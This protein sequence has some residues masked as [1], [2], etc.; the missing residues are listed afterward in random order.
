MFLKQGLVIPYYLL[1]KT[2]SLKLS[3]LAG[4]LNA[5]SPL[6]VLAREISGCTKNN[7]IIKSVSRY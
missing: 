1:L 5:L 2:K 3:A 7:E 6:A 4:K